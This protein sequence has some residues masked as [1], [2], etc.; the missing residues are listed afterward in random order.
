MMWL[1]LA[2]ALTATALALVS[3]KAYFS[4]SRRLA[5]LVTAL[6]LF[7]VAQLGFL[8][9]LTEVEVGVVY[10]SMGLVQVMVLVL[11][12][13]VLRERIT[14]DHIVAVALIVGGLILYAA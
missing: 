9:A 2:G 4:R 8:F 14:R 10:M 11:S 3:Y 5:L 12:S 6:G 7:V 1:V 13:T